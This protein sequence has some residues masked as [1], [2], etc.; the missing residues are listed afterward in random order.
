MKKVCFS[1]PTVLLRRPIA[2]I[3]NKINSNNSGLLLPKN[4]FSGFIKIHFNKFKKVKIHHYL[5]I[6]IPFSS[7]EW[8]IP[9]NPFYFFKILKIFKNYEIIHLW[10][11]FYITNTII[12]VI[13]KLIYPNKKI[14]LTMDTFPGFSLN[15][16]KILNSLFRLYYKSIGKF[17]FSHIDK[18]ILYS[19][20]MRRYTNNIGIPDHKIAVLPTGINIKPLPKDKNIRDEFNIKK[21]D[22]IILYVGI[23]NKRKNVEAI[24]DI[25]RTMRNSKI[26][27]VIVGD[28][29]NRRNIQ[30]KIN[31]FDLSNDVIMTGFRKDVYNFYNE[32]NLFLFTSKGEGLP[33]VI[34]EAMLYG[35]PVVATNI[36]EIQLIVK[37]KF[38]GF[39]C[40]KDDIQDFIDKIQILIKDEDLRQKFITNSKEVIKTKFDWNKNMKNYLELYL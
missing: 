40:D 32:A 27:F 2:E 12:P 13:S 31:S 35:V 8:P 24:I 7:F 5:S 22:T 29:P 20:S 15:L 30:E 1:C 11:P 18:I 14:Y 34:M 3:L 39:L 23:L 28:G 21:N 26:K 25:A 19:D 37:N 17:L 9:I 4:L 6:D 10:V 16:G 33:G 38:N 36:S